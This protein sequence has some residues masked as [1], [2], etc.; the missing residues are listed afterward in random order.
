MDREDITDLLNLGFNGDR[1]ALDTALE[2]LLGHLEARARTMLQYRRPLETKELLSEMFIRLLRQHGLVI[3]DRR[4]FLQVAG[5]LMHNVI[6]DSI[7]WHA[8]QKRS[9]YDTTFE[10]SQVAPPQ[11]PAILLEVHA[12]LEQVKAIDARTYQVAELHLLVGLTLEEIAEVQGRSRS[13]VQR[14]WKF[15]RTYLTSRLP[16]E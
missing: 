15:A 3:E 10:E 9:S 11:E 5:R 1:A 6:V 13:S 14:D 7:R 8:A 2:P 16:H 4:H 12:L